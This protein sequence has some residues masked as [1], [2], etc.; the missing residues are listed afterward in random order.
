MDV[1][2]HVHIY[3]IGCVDHLKSVFLYINKYIN[4]FVII[5]IESAGEEEVGV[6]HIDLE[7]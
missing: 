7:F 3:T 4:K 2:C 6:Q 5:P 1:K